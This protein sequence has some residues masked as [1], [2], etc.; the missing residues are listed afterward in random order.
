MS[1]I[2]LST[3]RISQPPKRKYNNSKKAKEVHSRV[4]RN[5]H[6]IRGKAAVKPQP[7]LLARDLG[8]AVPHAAVRQRAILVTRLLLQAGLDEV[9]GQAEEAGEEAGG[10]AGREGLGARAPGGA[11][12]QLALGL[13]EEGQLAEV[14]GHGARHGGQAA[15]PQRGHALGARDARQRVQHG[16]IMR[17]L[18]RRLEPV[19]LHADE[20]QVGRVADEGGEAAGAE[21]GGRALGEARRPARLLGARAGQAQEGVEEAEAGGGVDG[22][23]QQARAEARVQV[24]GAA[25][26]EQ[27]ARD[28]QRGGARRARPPRRALAR[29]LQPHLDHVDGLDHRRGRHA[30]QAAVDEGQR[31]AGVGVVQ[32]ARGG[33]GGVVAGLLGRVGGLL[34]GGGGGAGHGGRRGAGWA[35]AERVESWVAVPG[36][37]QRMHCHC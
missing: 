3:Q 9:E 18:G 24:A 27:L 10:G 28:G 29:Q 14:E 20:R 30:G 2:I 33:G 32:R 19:A 15:G 17:P 26:G 6:V 13:G 37:G 1:V 23:A 31:R 34:R 12:G 36:A 5:A 35:G 16:A 25:G 21:P 4:R 8:S 22:L 11:R 7:A